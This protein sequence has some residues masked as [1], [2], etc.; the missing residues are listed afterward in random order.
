MSNKKIQRIK[1][2]HLFDSIDALLI[3]K[4]QNILYILGFDIESE[5]TILILNMEKS[6]HYS[7]I[8][9]F[10]NALEYDE[11]KAQIEQNTT[12]KNEIEIIKI[13]K[14]EENVIEKTIKQL[15][16]NKLGFEDDFINVKLFEQFK[17]KFKK[18][19]LI[20]ASEILLDARLIKTEKEIQKIK[21][22]A[23]LGIIGFNT[24]FERIEEEMTEKEL[25]AMAEYAMR[26]EGADGIAFKTIVASGNRSAFPHGKTSE[27]KIRKGDI[28]IVDIGAIYDG[29]CSDMTRSFIFDGKNAQN[30]SKKAEL[31]NLVNEGQKK[32]LD[33]VKGGKKASELDSIVREFF[34]NENKEWGERFIHS[35][36][37]GVGIEVHEEPYISSISEDILK[38]GMCITI[39]PGLYIQGLGGARTEDLL[40]VKKNGYENLT[41]KLEKFY[42]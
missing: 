4:P 20:G 37:H 10:V 17:E 35:L 13:A 14:A 2:H 21:K 31:I 29:Y 1:N 9:V 15:K 18:I 40:V 33:E 3:R 36:G 23:E 12:L 25:A 8:L 34:K 6:K 30:F 41:S 22:A 39:E 16:L 19:K 26:K 5:T 24:I 27:K 42:Y 11:T 7:Q 28:I 32:A 38:K